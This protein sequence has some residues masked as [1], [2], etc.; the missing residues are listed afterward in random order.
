MP[1]PGTL[2]PQVAA[3][4]VSVAG[5]R[6]LLV[7][8]GPASSQAGTWALPGGRI[9]PGE[10]ARDAA[11]RELREE[12]GLRARAGRFVGWTE[13]LTADAHYVILTFEVE[14]IDPPSGALAGDDADAVAWVPLAEVADHGLVEG[15]ADFLV[16]HGIVPSSA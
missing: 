3:S 5:G 11:V 12:T 2:R 1:T 15:L 9:E 7:R 6:L 13:K 10:R 8:R 4:V 14:L 16:D